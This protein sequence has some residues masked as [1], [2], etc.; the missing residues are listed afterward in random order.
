MFSFLK[1]ESIGSLSC[2]SYASG[3][4]QTY[5]QHGESYS[6]MILPAMASVRQN[7]F[8]FNLKI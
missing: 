8:C 1:G 5:S 7:F 6:Q 2:E 4:S 3:Q